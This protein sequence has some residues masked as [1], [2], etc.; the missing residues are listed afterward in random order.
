MTRLADY[1]FKAK[2]KLHDDA[3]LVE[4]CSGRFWLTSE[5]SRVWGPKPGRWLSKIG[6]SVG[7]ET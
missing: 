3:D 2:A 5:G 6:Y 1:G 7:I 4:F